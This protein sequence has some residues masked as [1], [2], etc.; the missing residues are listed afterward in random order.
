M[1]PGLNG[2]LV[3]LRVSS[4]LVASEGVTV[5]T[6]LTYFCCQPGGETLVYFLKDSEQT[7]AN[8]C[9][10]TIQLLAGILM[11]GPK[12]FLRELLVQLLERHILCLEV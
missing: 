1:V 11:R 10:E 5:G 9:G 6:E 8:C 12:S 4:V 7:G 3:E 2:V